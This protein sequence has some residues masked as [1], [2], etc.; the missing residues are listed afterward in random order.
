MSALRDQLRLALADRH[1]PESRALFGW[2]MARVANRVEAAG[3]RF[4]PDL[5]HPVELEEISSE[6]MVQ[7]IAGGLARFNGDELPSLLAYVRTIADRTL[8]RRVRQRLHE[9]AAL[10]ARGVEAAE[11]WQGR[12]PEPEAQI[13]AVPVCPL[14]EADMLYLMELL[15]AGSRI[16]LARRQGVSRAAVTQRVQ[17]IQARISAL[18][19]SERGAAEAW[20]NH[21]AASVLGEEA[22]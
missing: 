17:R 19:P 1:A 11:D 6:V 18:S 20:M 22:S 9:R 4:T 12:F 8:S 13:Q 5:L 15:R 21:A 10:A 3:R 7:L 2:L 16:E 14:A